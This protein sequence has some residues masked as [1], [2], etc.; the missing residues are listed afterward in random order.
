[1]HDFVR[2]KTFRKVYIFQA[3]LKRMV[4]AIAFQQISKCIDQMMDDDH[5]NYD[6]IGE[7]LLIGG[8][9]DPLS[10]QYRSPFRDGNGREHKTVQ[11]Y[12]LY[13]LAETFED[14]DAMARILD[15]EMSSAAEE[16]A[17]SI[18]VR[19]ELLGFVS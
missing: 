18:K 17:N 10:A 4:A 2:D 13:K 19:R 1:M 11:R 9:K 5:F 14:Q 12:V 3:K 16:A 7:F 15:A 8:L 6:D